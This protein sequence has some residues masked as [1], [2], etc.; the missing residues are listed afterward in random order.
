MSLCGSVLCIKC[1]L[2]F[3]EKTRRPCTGTCN[4]SICEQC[5]DQK[6]SPSCPIC[7]NID[8]FQTKNIN[9]KAVE[10]MEELSKNKD[11]LSI[12]N[13]KYNPDALCAGTCSECKTHTD[14]LRICVDCL[15]RSGH[16]AKTEN[17]NFEMSQDSSTDYPDS[18]ALQVLSTG[19]CA[20]CCIDGAHKEHE[21]TPIKQFVSLLRRFE[22]L[23]TLSAIS[24]D[25]L[26][27]YNDLEDKSDLEVMNL[28]LKLV[29]KI[30]FKFQEWI[31][32]AFQGSV[33]TDA[34]RV[35]M[36]RSTERLH[37]FVQKCNPVIIQCVSEI[38]E[39]ASEKDQKEWQEINQKLEEYQN[40]VSSA[41][42]YTELGA[43]DFQLIDTVLECF[44]EDD[45]D[46]DVIEDDMELD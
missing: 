15:T 40:T 37:Y 29:E 7:N 9:W 13:F 2:V 22:N 26:T 43:R 10:I 16:V 8:S 21:I 44:N 38:L 45:E 20:D 11:Y 31:D 17:G 4:H 24:L 18:S 32:N 5:F 39:S 6:H 1:S 12:D 14:K 27:P 42:K 3:D 25:L 30:V 46:S 34:T 19:M 41:D 23:N 28:Y 33:Q 35:A 36:K